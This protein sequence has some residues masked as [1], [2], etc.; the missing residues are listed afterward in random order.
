MM[1]KS[2]MPAAGSLLVDSSGV[3]ALVS[4]VLLFYKRKTHPG[5]S[6]LS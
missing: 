5:R 4:S 2:P 6:Q 3:S 1:L